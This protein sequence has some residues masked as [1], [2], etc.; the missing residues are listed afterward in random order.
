MLLRCAGT[1]IIDSVD[2]DS[3]G[4]KLRGKSYWPTY[5][6]VSL[7]SPLALTRAE[8]EPIFQQTGSLEE[9]LDAIDAASGQPVNGSLALTPDSMDKQQQ[10]IN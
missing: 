6:K 3:V 9:V 5:R 8:A 1:G 2:W 4:F 7:G 10:S